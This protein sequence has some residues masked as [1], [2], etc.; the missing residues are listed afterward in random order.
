MDGQDMRHRRRVRWR[1]FPVRV[2]SLDYR[3]PPRRFTPGRTF[4][5]ATDAMDPHDLRPNRPDRLTVV[6]SVVRTPRRPRFRAIRYHTESPGS[7]FFR[8]VGQRS[9]T[10][11][12]QVGCAALTHPTTP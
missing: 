8:R 10:H 2:P 6:G 3:G 12:I 7:G 5:V 9:A 4:F 1:P 11:R